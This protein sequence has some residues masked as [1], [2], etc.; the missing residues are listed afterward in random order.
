MSEQQLAQAVREA[1]ARLQRAG[2]SSARHDAEAL[3]AHVLGR[4]L[5]D[6]RLAVLRG[7]DVT[8][9][10]RFTALVDERC[11]RVPLQHLTG[12]APFRGVD[13]AVGPGVFVPR[14]ETEVVAQPAVDEAQRILTAEG[15]SAVVV[16]LCTGS[17]AIAIAVA[18]EV[19]HAEVHAVE[20]DA[21]ALAWAQRNVAAHA[22]RV[23]L[24]QGDAATACPD[25]EG[26]C[27]V[28]VSNPPYVPPDCV[29]VDPEV[30][31][32]DP[33]VALYG[34]GPDGLQVPRQVIARAAEL[35]A[36][37]GLLVVEH[38]DV[39]QDALLRALTTSGGWDDA[40]GHRDLTGRPRYVTARRRRP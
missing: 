24:R 23:D 8:L 14:P 5:G 17:G 37:G 3:A 26:V 10:E 34:R 25:L 40:R 4:P 33:E 19:P 28:V 13:L 2:V 29:P 39:Q 6:V 15:R 21:Q 1:T 18:R 12:T 32:H 7:D 16:D 9:G 31:D 22:P 35:L 11:R 38:A 36:E 20:L 30:R 27:D